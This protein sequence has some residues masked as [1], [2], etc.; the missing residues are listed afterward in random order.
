M[1]KN[2]KGFYYLF[3]VMILNLLLAS[4]TMAPVKGSVIEHERLVDGVYEGRY[5]HGLNSAVVKVTVAQ[6][7]IVDIEVVKHFASWKGDKATEVIPQRIISEQSTEVDAVSGAT[8]SSR[9]IMNAV[10]NAVEKGFE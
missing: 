4:C 2:L 7:Q 10:Q 5:R 1:R 3:F 8:N 6:G 9:V